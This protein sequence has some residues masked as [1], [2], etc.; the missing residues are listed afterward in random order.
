[1]EAV[2]VP[3]VL[4]VGAVE[5]GDVVD[6]L[7]EV[8]GVVEVV[9]AGPVR[10]K[11][12]GGLVE[13]H[14]RHRGVGVA[15]EIAAEHPVAAGDRRASPPRPQPHEAVPGGDLVVPPDDEGVGRVVA[16]RQGVGG[17]PQ[18]GPR[19]RGG[20]ARLVQ[21]RH[22]VERERDREPAG[23]PLVTK[24]GRPSLA[25]CAP[26]HGE[27]ARRPERAPNELPA[28]HG[29]AL[30]RRPRPDGRGPPRPF[31]LGGVSRSR[32]EPPPPPRSGKA[33]QL[34]GATGRT[35]SPLISAPGASRPR[36]VSTGSIPSGCGGWRAGRRQPSS[37]C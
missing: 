31:S 9:E 12:A 1:M 3:G 8:G 37:P 14:E 36:S 5:V 29:A 27:R 25:P 10:S 24:R 21:P 30:H 34:A 6:E 26:G 11:E 19:A 28:S 32:L 2:R 16:P 15:L 22:V 17:V 18:N 35:S 7:P 20:P 13:D 23:G 4:P 33:R